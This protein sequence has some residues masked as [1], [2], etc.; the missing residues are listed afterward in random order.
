M[1]ATVTSHEIGHQMS[2]QHTFNNCNGNE[3]P[4]NAFE[5]GSGTTIM[6]YSGLCGGALNVI[7]GGDDYYHVASLIQI[8]N[9]TREGIAG[10]GCAEQ[11]ATS[12]LEPTA[13]LTVSTPPCSPAPSTSRSR[14]YR[15]MF[16]HLH[17]AL[18]GPPAPQHYTM[19]DDALTTSL[20][21]CGE[22]AHTEATTFVG[23][24]G[25]PLLTHKQPAIPTKWAPLA[26]RLVGCL[27]KM[28]A[29]GGAV[30]CKLDPGFKAPG[31]NKSSNS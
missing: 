25:D 23:A 1:A 30:R 10:D 11:I 29:G 19:R 24:S 26:D 28:R 15:C 27:V 9:H 21:R 5:P 4:G 22:L 18:P 14:L 16:T 20:R 6:S 2:A 8:Y 31:F 3:S 7:N 12:N 13:F 17:E